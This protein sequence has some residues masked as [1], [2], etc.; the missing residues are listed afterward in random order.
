MADC[1]FANFL[2]MFGRPAVSNQSLL[3]LG[4]QRGGELLPTNGASFAAKLAT[5]ASGFAAMTLAPE[6]PVR[7]QTFA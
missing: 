4:L 6:P 2:S 5:L 3:F 1:G 7:W